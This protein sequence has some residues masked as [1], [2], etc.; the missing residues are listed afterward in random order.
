[1]MP[2]SLFHYDIY[3]QAGQIGPVGKV[4]DWSVVQHPISLLILCDLAQEWLI[5]SWV[6]T[7]IAV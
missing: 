1:M 6:V 5:K 2:F 3:I 4:T 7:N